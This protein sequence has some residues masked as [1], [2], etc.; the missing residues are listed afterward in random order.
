MYTMSRAERET[1]IRWDEDTKKARYY[2]CS[3]PERRK[4]DKKCADY[5]EVFRKVKEDAYSAT[6][7]LPV[8]RIAIRNPPSEARMASGRALGAKHGF[9]AIID[10]AAEQ[11]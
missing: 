11:E 10:D 9:K 2:T 7:E 5:P 6:Y 4:L 8:D 1:I 3:E